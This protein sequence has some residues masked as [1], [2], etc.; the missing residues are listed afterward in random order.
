MQKSLLLSGYLLL[1]FAVACAPKVRTNITQKY[2]PLD[3]KE[4]VLVIELPDKAPESAE[5]LGTIKIGDAGMSVQCSYSQVLGKAKEEARKA[6]GN[7]IRI[8]A[9]KTPDFMSSCHRISAEVLRIDATVLAALKADNEEV[10]PGIDYAVLYVYRTGGAGIIINY[11]LSLGDSVICRVTNRFSQAIKIY[12]Q[13]PTE[14]SAKTEAKSVIPIDIQKGRSY[15]VRCSVIPGITIGRPGL[16]LMS[17]K[18]G[19]RE[20]ELA[21]SKSK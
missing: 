10:E 3:Y 13:G 12:K 18:A 11:N 20:Y 17:K 2:E 15:Y 16:E 6:G 7:A 14:L 21:K 5:S 19:S 8:T 4:E 9:H 1:L